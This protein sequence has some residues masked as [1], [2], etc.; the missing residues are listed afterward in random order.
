MSWYFTKA[1]RIT[2]RRKLSPEAQAILDRLGKYLNDNSAEPVEIL[3]GFWK[4]QQDAITYQELRKLVEEGY[5]D[6][7]TAR[8]WEQDYSV[9]VK[10]QMPKIWNHAIIA[11]A[12]SQPLME[13]TLG[14]WTFNT[15][16]PGVMRWIQSRGAYMV[17]VSTQTQKDAIAL[18][19]E[20]KMRNGH[21]V[22]ELARLIRPCVGLYRQQASAVS[23]YYDS[24]IKAL[25]EQHPR[26]KPARIQAMALDKATKYAERLH[27]QR[28]LMI[29]QTEM[30]FAYNYGA[31]EGIRQAQADFLIGKCIKRWCTAGDNNVCDACKDLN[32]TEIGMDELFYSGSRVVYEETGLYPPLHPRCGCAVQYIEV[33]APKPFMRGVDVTKEYIDNATPGVGTV[34]L[35]DGYEE[36]THKA[37]IETAEWLHKNLGGNIRLLHESNEQ[38]VKTADY[39]WRD[40]LWDL[41]S[42]TSEKAANSAIR[43]G[44]HQIEE[45]PGGIIL[46]YGECD[47]RLALL[48]SFIEKR[49]QWYQRPH[50]DI[51]VLSRGE[52]LEALR[53]GK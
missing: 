20:D 23:N 44:L 34:E 30:A 9:L 41:K 14:A 28:A 15:Q 21:T 53:Y 43:Y 49:M 29:A 27:R 13:R 35:E 37:E 2:K 40:K 18:L 42:V 1:R 38:R 4:D 17:T 52:L 36:A 7:V 19:Q 3:C 5:L 32:G 48:N 25:T 24:M 47:I 51:L 16:T 10:E 39:L 22:D 26:T 46:N 45:N 8:L 50:A 12:A 31:D 6:E 11:G 33:E